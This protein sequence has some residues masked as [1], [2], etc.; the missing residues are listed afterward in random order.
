[1]ARVIWQMPPDSCDLST[2]IW[3]RWRVR[4]STAL[5]QWRRYGTCIPN[6]CAGLLHFCYTS[7]TLLL[8]YC[9]TVQVLIHLYYA[10]AMLLLYYCY[11]AVTPLFHFCYTSTLLVCYL[12]LHFSYT[13][14]TLLQHS[15][16][17]SAIPSSFDPRNVSSRGV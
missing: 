10:S 8:H 2:V 17:G 12:P 11:A 7:A 9:Y 6:S 13:F 15:L 5:V 3:Q 1:M 4:H 14:P 16:S